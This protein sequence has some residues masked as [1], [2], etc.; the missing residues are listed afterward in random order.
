MAA[1]W[2]KAE[3]GRSAQAGVRGVGGVEAARHVSREIWEV[4]LSGYR[5]LLNG[6]KYLEDFLHRLRNPQAQGGSC[7][8]PTKQGTSSL[9]HGPWEAPVYTQ[10][11]VFHTRCIAKNWRSAH[12][13]PGL[14]EAPRA[15][16]PYHTNG[17]GIRSEAA[18]FGTSGWMLLLQQIWGRGSVDCRL[19]D[20]SKD[21]RLL[22]P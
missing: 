11:P 13:G 10:S 5:Q 9:K 12:S 21:P 3:A 8:A 19:P 16:G 22:W 1:P 18:S 4:K 7:S 6:C 20:V 2:R 14:G 17:G 15:L